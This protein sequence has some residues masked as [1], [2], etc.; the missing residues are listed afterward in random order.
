MKWSFRIGSIFGI[1][2]RVHLTF[3]LLLFFIALSGISRE[4]SQGA[5][6]GIVSIVSIFVCVIL[7]EVGHSLMARH[8]KINVRD[9]VLLPIGGVSQMEDIPEEP[10]QEILISVVGPLV[11]FGLAFLFLL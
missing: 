6:F 11:S 4:G 1:P 10:N 9:I 7:H 2:I 8:Y 5:V 3:L